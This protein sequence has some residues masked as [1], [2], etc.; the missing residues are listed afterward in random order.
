MA[1]R[2]RWDEEAS[3]ICPSFCLNQSP[4]V[5]LISKLQQFLAVDLTAYLKLGGI[6]SE[7]Y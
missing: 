5:P 1:Q 4:R 6:L 2:E 7:F 3:M